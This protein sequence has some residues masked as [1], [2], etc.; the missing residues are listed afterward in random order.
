M[1]ASQGASTYFG[2]SNYHSLQAGWKYRTTKGLTL[3]AAYTWGKT[4]TD[5]G[6]HGF[7]GRNAGTTGQ[8][9]ND[10][11]A[12]YGPPG[13]DRTHI[14]TAS[15]VWELPLLKNRPDLVGKAFGNWTLSGITV[16]E[17]GLAIAP[18]MS[19]STNG[20][21]ARPDCSGSVGG[22]KSVA[23]WFNSA[24]FTAPAFGF[25]GNCG[26]GIIRGPGENTWN[27][28]LFKDFPIKERAKLQF[29][30]EFFNVW[31]HPNF[32]QVSNNLGAGNF[33]AVT[34]ALE[35]RIIEFALR[36]QF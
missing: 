24:A 10:L 11:K 36:F 12:D 29:R 31:N 8:N 7:D 18:G 30:S 2:T 5:V 20:L 6:N 25:F 17:S 34:T 33:G 22:Q 9:S 28:A 32:S 13:W 14:F 23:E 27:V 26:T 3:T 1:T 4:L 16:I 15:Y 21:A 35:P 19:T